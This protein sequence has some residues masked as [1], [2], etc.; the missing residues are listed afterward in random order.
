M[1]FFRNIQIMYMPI[2]GDTCLTFA[3]ERPGASAD[4]G[5]YSGDK[6]HMVRVPKTT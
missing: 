2:Q 5:E 3:L 1:V 4:Q 6:L